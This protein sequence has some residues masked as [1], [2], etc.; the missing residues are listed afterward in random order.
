MYIEIGYVYLEG[1]RLGGGV[2]IV[3]VYILREYV[4]CVLRRCVWGGR[5]GGSTW[6]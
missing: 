2:I 6:K 5:G 1:V 4:Y 3:R